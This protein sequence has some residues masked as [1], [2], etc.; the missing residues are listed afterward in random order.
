MNAVLQ[1]CELLLMAFLFVSSFH[2][3]IATYDCSEM[4]KQFNA[5]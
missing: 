1:L 5:S 4:H 2:K 3:G